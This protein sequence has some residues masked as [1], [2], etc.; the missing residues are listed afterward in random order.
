[1]IRLF[2]ESNSPGTPHF[3]SKRSILLASFAASL[4][5]V[6]FFSLFFHP[7]WMTNDD[8]GMSM[9]A[10]GYGAVA[11]GSPNLTF[12]NVLWGYLVGLIPEINGVLGYSIAT[13]GILV[14][15]GTTLIYGLVRLGFGY[16]TTLALVTLVLVRPVLFPQF[17]INA[18]LLMLS[19]II[20]WIVYVRQNNSY[21]LFAGGALAFLSYLVRSHEFVLILIVALPLI[22]WQYLL[23]QRASQLIFLILILA[24]AVAAYI[25]QHSALG[26]EW[27]SFNLL[28]P[29]RALF[30]DY[31]AGRYLAQRPDLLQKYGFSINDINLISSWFFVDPNI[32]NP[33]ALKAMLDE[34]GPLPGRSD[35]I[36]KAWQSIKTFLHPTLL[37]QVL[38]ALLLAVLR[39]NW[40]VAVSWALSIL[41]MAALGFLGRP[42]VLHV[43]IALVSLL[44]IA[45]FLV[46]ASSYKVL[47]VFRQRLVILVVVAVAIFNTTVVIQQNK[48]KFA[49]SE[50]IRQGLSNFPTSSVLIWGAVFPF[51][52]TYQVLKQSSAVMNYRLY[53]LGVFTLAPFSTSFE[54]EKTNHITDL[55]MSKDGILIIVD[56]ESLEFLNI[57]CRERLNGKLVEISIQRYGSVKVR[58]LRCIVGL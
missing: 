50:S 31:G 47:G 9:I 16:L 6:F 28:N 21:A 22:P 58:R 26:S 53:A 54:D 13:L 12:S 48:A 56:K 4:S 14:I 34:L 40:K 36:M 38:A 3:L 1:M 46:E 27:Q 32:A 24:I 52:A 18:G 30:T 25:D 17:T 7:I 2:C 37:P 33:K 41:A 42:S 5:F 51:E 49:S 15:V 8:V 45:P 11:V 19:A 57:Y 20:C 44:L 23:R 43:Y 55:L 39:P 10:H 35:G 29:V